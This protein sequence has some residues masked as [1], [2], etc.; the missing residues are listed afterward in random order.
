M[1]DSRW[2]TGA[3]HEVDT[4]VIGEFVNN[5]RVSEFEQTKEINEVFGGMK[6]GSRRDFIF[7]TGPRY[8]KEIR[9]SAVTDKTNLQMGIPEKEKLKTI[10]LDTERTGIDF[11]E[12]T[13]LEKMTRV[14]D[15]NMGSSWRLSPGFSPNVGQSEDTVSFQSTFEDRYLIKNEHLAQTKLEYSGRKIFN[16][17]DNQKYSLL[18]KY[19]HQLSDDNTLVFNTRIEGGEKL[20]SDNLIELGSENGLRGFKTDSIVGTKSWLFNIENRTFFIEELWNLF[21]IGSAVFLD[22][23]YVWGRGEPIRLSQLRSEVGGGLRIGLTK[24]SNEVILRLDVSYRLHRVHSSDSEWV[25]SFGTGQ[26][27]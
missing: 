4:S 17:G 12:L 15:V 20:D 1:T 7:R 8:R 14:E 9:D 2:T 19:Y 5:T 22:S 24:S 26:G 18:F 25:F 6:I 27:F 23:G 3:W 11:M 21:S 13:R 10:F 16:G